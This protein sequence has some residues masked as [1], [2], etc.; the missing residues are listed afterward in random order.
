MS[1][2]IPNPQ[3][4]LYPLIFTWTP[5]STPSSLVCLQSPLKILCNITK[6]PFKSKKD[7]WCWCDHR[8]CETA[9]W[10]G[11][12][13][14]QTWQ[15]FFWRK[16]YATELPAD[17]CSRILPYILVVILEARWPC[18]PFRKDTHQ[19]NV[20]RSEWKYLSTSLQVGR[21]LKNRVDVALPVSCI[22]EIWLK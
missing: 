7:R 21:V 13:D 17:I 10:W 22:T 2:M 1:L 8:S 4:I 19:N 9:F 18:V 15:S 5:A 6:I 12:L 20:A 11:W 16:S 14:H 3:K